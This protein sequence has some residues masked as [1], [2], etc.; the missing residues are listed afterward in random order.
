MKEAGVDFDN[1]IINPRWTF[2]G[3]LEISQRLKD[4]DINTVGVG[5]DA[6]LELDSNTSLSG[7]LKSTG[8][9]DVLDTNNDNFVIGMLKPFVRS[10]SQHHS[11]LAPRQ[12]GRQPCAQ[13]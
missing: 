11:V 3:M 9:W 6:L 13:V 10:Q 7:F 4:T 5:L 2:D 1:E 12:S 8:K